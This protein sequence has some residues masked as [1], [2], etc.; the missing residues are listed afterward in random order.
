MASNSAW[1]EKFCV[2]II[3]I[4]YQTCQKPCCSTCWYFSSL[5]FAKANFWMSNFNLAIDEGDRSAS[6]DVQQ[7]SKYGYITHHGLCRLH[8]KYHHTQMGYTVV[9]CIWN[10]DAQQRQRDFTWAKLC[11]MMSV[12]NKL[13]Y[14]LVSI[15]LLS[16]DIFAIIF[17]VKFKTNNIAFTIKH[18]FEGQSNWKM[19]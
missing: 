1:F 8:A 19:D 12:S 18:S 16:Q 14:L 17:T 13:S 3:F 10:V 6:C 5:H 11:Y 9:M 15:I 7:Y 2:E 4:D